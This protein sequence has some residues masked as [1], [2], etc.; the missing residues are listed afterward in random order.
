MAGEKRH[1]RRKLARVDGLEDVGHEPP[2][3]EAPRCGLEPPAE[4]G[5]IGEER[6]API[7]RAGKAPPLPHSGSS[8]VVREGAGGRE[9]PGLFPLTSLEPRCALG[10]LAVESRSHSTGGNYG[11]HC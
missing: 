11:S 4:A 2:L 8:E 5:E 3:V 9:R 6:H 7:L 10:V 1:R